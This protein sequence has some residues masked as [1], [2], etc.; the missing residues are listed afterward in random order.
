[1]VCEL[2]DVDDAPLL[3]R[4]EHGHDLGRLDVAYRTFPNDR[5]H[6][7][8]ES[9]PNVVRMTRTLADTPLLKPC[10]RDDSEGPLRGFFALPLGT[11]TLSDRVD[12]GGNQFA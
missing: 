9:P 10:R 7:R 6:I 11:P 1:M 12:A 2:G 8:L 3:D 5:E 4:L